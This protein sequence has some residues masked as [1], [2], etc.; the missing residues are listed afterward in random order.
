[1]PEVP[2][3]TSAILPSSLPQYCSPFDI[4]A[5]RFARL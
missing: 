4:E 1:M 2:P 3:V 5:L